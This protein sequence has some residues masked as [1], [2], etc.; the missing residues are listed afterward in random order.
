MTESAV[1]LPSDLQ[2]CILY[3]SNIPHTSIWLADHDLKSPNWAGD[4]RKEDAMEEFIHREKLK[5]FRRQLA[6]AK[7]EVQRQ[8]LF[9]L[10]AEEETRL[11]VA[12][13]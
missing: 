4:P 9:K 7:D 11:P 3:N 12:T 5:I 2:A 6:V 1:A 10:L 8:L 13:K